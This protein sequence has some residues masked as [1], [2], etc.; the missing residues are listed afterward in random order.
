MASPTPLR[1]ELL[2][3]LSVLFASGILVAS[4]GLALILPTVESPLETVLYILTVLI[5]ELGVIFLFGRVALGRAL[6]KPLDR[7]VADVETMANGAYEPRV[8]PAP[9]L[10]LQAVADSV[11]AMAE[12]LI[13][14]QKALAEN[15]ASLDETNRA[16]VEARAQ[17]VRAARLASTGTLA[18]G[19]AHELG[20]PLGALL[21]YVDVARGRAETGGDDGE[22][23]D[24][25]REEA[26]RI[27][28]IIRSLLDVARSK[29]TESG[30]Q[31]PWPVVERVKDLL[32]AQGRLEG[33]DGRPAGR[34]G[35]GGDTRPA[36]L[37]GE[38][39]GHERD[40]HHA[41]GLAGV[42]H[43][44]SDP[45]GHGRARHDE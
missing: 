28:R 5:A 4:V 13:H 9:T 26:I 15:V 29:D 30:P 20:N 33:V 12:R 43:L 6:F 45:V 37:A 11:N 1:R 7:L 22:L 21:A 44:V 27:D 14:D 34:C 35:V 39:C 2:I 17:V 19:I 16:L 23:L 24:S 8:R 25:I 10:E 38:R 32:E 3:A 18:S 31:H 36:N 40:D 41:Q 42:A